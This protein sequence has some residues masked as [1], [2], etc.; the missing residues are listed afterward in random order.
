MLFLF[1]Q[2]YLGGSLFE[3]S[4]SPGTLMA[5]K[6]RLQEAMVSSFSNYLHWFLCSCEYINSFNKYRN[7]FSWWWVIVV[8]IQHIF[9]VKCIVSTLG[10]NF[11][12]YFKIQRLQGGGGELYCPEKSV[13]NLWSYNIRS[14]R[15][16]TVASKS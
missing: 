9:F 6:D 7:S 11:P 15:T 5:S 13:Q 14:S 12:T 8:R 4:M 10:N 16:A 1:Q 3:M 2:T